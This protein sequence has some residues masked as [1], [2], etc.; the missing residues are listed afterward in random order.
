MNKGKKLW[1]TSKKII[2]N[3]NLLLSKHPDLYLP[4]KWPT[5]FSKANKIFVWDLDNVKYTDFIFSVGTNTLGYCNKKIDNAV[6]ANIRNSN[7]ATFNCPE[8]SKLATEMLKIHKWAGM[9]KY[10]RTGAEANAIAIRIARCSVNKKNIAICGYH[11]WHDW[12]MAANIGKNDNLSEHLLKGIGYKG[13][14]NYLKGS[15]H[16]FNYNDLNSFKKLIKYRNIGIV[17]MEVARS[18]SINVKFLR[19]I[20]NLCNKNNII[21]IF[22]ECTSGFREY[23][24]G[25]HLKYNIIPD[26]A[27]FGKALGNGYAI[28]TIVGKKNIMIKSEQSFISST[29]WTERVGYT[30]ALETL[31]EMK[32]NKS[33]EKISKMGRF[34]KKKWAE[35]A[36]KN[37]IK[38]K[39]QG[40][41][42]IPSF[43]FLENHL[44]YKTFL[45][46]E[47]L[48]KKYLATNFIFISTEHKKEFV[49]KYLKNIDYIFKKISN[50]INANIN[51]KDLIDTETSASSFKRLN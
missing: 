8:E 25:L 16:P 9:V 44:I 5:Y 6:I 38:I 29:F 43:I 37:S 19:E 4:N 50:S 39:I 11:G 41:D 17:I 22:D 12:Y 24:G 23:F 2:P 51:P 49:L 3:G 18:V 46:Q 30:A 33:W 28:N 47:M 14:P 13:I 20:R 21:L 32:K 26:L 15:V 35:I 7:M 42:A 45:T 34:I 27:M 36:K 48:K 40:L 31:K 1:E 10:A